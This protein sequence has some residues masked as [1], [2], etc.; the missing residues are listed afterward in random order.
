VLRNIGSNWALILVTIGSSYVLTPFIIRTLGRDGYGTWTLMNA[1][2]GYIGLLSLGVPAACVRY[3]AQHV[4]ERDSKK[5]NVMVASCAGLYLMIGAGAAIV[6]GILLGF[7]TAFEIPTSFRADAQLAFG[8]MV[9]YVSAGFIGLLPEGILFAHHDFVRRNLIRIGGILLRLV[10]TAGLLTLH[11]SLIV[12]A[13]I[14]MACLASD[15]GLSWFLVKRRY[16]DV[17]INLADFDLSVVR[18]ILSFSLFVLLL[19]AGS[20]LSFE[21]DALVIGWR[22]GVGLIPFYVVAN[23]LIVYLMEFVIGI[24]AVVSPMATTLNTQGK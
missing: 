12:L 1:M 20:R 15:F 14:Q 9:L 4:A 5:I 23:S 13:L 22:L 11:P 8:L 21:T 24:A 16:P 18:R 2:T 19:A 3:L 10:L 17:R 7:F 6:G